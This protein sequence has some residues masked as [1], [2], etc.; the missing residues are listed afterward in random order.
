[1]MLFLI[2][3]AAP[4]APP[5]STPV[6]AP[7]EA[8]ISVKRIAPPGWESAI[9][10]ALGY[11][12]SSIRAEKASEVTVRAVVDAGGKTVPYL[13]DLEFGESTS[14][15]LVSGGAV[16]AGRG[17]EG[18]K[19]YWAQEKLTAEQLSREL[20][21]EL[22]GYFKVLERGFLNTPYWEWTDIDSWAVS[23]GV[24]PPAWVVEAGVGILTVERMVPGE[25]DG[26]VV[27]LKRVVLGGVEGVVV[28]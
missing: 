9:D 22:V 27:E 11:L 24:K 21:V 26:G 5:V 13:L 18:F 12:D 2:C 19:N 14:R 7:W 15:L 28:R 16:V 6:A 4:A 8:T 10:V 1:M 20:S 23:H 25:G 3:C 17:L